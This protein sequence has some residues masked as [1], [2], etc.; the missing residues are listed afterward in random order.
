[1]AITTNDIKFYESTDNLGGAITGTE[2]V[3]ATVHN[4]FDVVDSDGALLGET[5]YR[6]IYVKN[7]HA[8]LTLTSALMYIESNTDLANTDVSIGVGTSVLGGV[9]QTIPDEDT[10][11]TGITWVNDIGV[12]N[13]ISLGNITNASWQAVWIRRVVLSNTASALSDSATFAV[14]GDTLP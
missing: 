7:I 1:M 3:N 2:V 8:T 10:E 9:E 14:Q 11:P 4:L 13:S 12:A 5:N 6:C